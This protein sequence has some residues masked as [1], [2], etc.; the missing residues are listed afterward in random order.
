MMQ[1]LINLLIKLEWVY[2]AI[3]GGIT[4]WMSFSK[5]PYNIELLWGL[6]KFK[7][8]NRIFTWSFHLNS[9]WSHEG[10]LVS[11][12]N[13]KS[14]TIYCPSKNT[15]TE[16]FGPSRWIICLNDIMLD[17]AL[18]SSHVPIILCWAF[19][20]IRSIPLC[21]FTVWAHFCGFLWHSLGFRSKWITRRFKC[22]T[23]WSAILIK[24]SCFPTVRSIAVAVM[25][26]GWWCN[27]S[28][29]ARARNINV[30]LR[31]LRFRHLTMIIILLTSTWT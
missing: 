24:T 3:L 15:G 5:F 12:V 28:H 19:W 27:T 25:L 2:C 11:H 17:W 7:Q 1:V 22:C 26:F 16:K 6:D 13:S 20:V 10:I 8:E 21:W 4:E 23:W 14:S 9:S 31:W 30:W 18:F 29:A